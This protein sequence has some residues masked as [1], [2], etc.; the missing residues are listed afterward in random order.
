MLARP[1]SAGKTDVLS[2]SFC[3]D[4]KLKLVGHS[5]PVLAATETGLRA[6]YRFLLMFRFGCD[7]A[8]AM[9]VELAAAAA[10]KRYRRYRV[11]ENQLLLRARFQNDRILIKALNPPCQLDTAHQVDRNIAAFFSGTVEEPILNCVLLLCIFFHQVV[12]PKVKV[13]GNLKTSK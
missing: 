3:G 5:A 13:L 2:L 8:A 1:A 9:R 12:S 7:R 6:A 4:D 10:R 11:L